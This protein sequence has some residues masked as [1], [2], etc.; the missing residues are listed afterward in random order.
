M[1]LS[2]LLRRGGGGSFA[3]SITLFISPPISLPFLTWFF[4]RRK[5]LPLSY[6]IRVA[7]CGRHTRRGNHLT[8]LCVSKYPP[9]FFSY[10]EESVTFGR[11]TKFSDSLSLTQATRKI[12]RMGDL[13][14]VAAPRRTPPS[15]LGCK[16]K[17]SFSQD[18]WRWRPSYVVRGKR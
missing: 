12:S 8:Q 11:K 5:S 9:D 14:L 16:E 1:P 6:V 7:V 2:H 15:K 4:G 10:R 3:S 18:F 17:S 13:I